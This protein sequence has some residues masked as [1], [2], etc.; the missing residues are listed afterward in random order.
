MRQKLLLER[1]VLVHNLKSNGLPFPV[2]RSI[3]HGW[4]KDIPR[5]GDRV[6]FTGCTYQ[7]AHLG[8]RYDKLLEKVPKSRFVSKFSSLGGLLVRPDQGE[9]ERAYNVLRRMARLL[10]ES[11]VE[12]G[13]LYEKEPYSGTILWEMGMMGEFWDYMETIR[14]LLRSEGVKEVITVDPHTHYTL[15]LGLRK[16]GIK[17]TNWLELVRPKRVV[18]NTPLTIHDSCLYTRYLGMREKVR[19]LLSGS[20]LREDPLITGRETSSCCGGPVAPVDSTVS[21]KIAQRRSKDLMKL[22]DTVVVSC[23]FCYVN[24]SPH[25]RVVDMAEVLE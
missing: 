14:E 15:L 10:T 17:V 1:D 9:V 12:F 6:I 5:G 25:V 19:G 8:A 2:D 23:P 22:A 24:L 16:D 13:Y 7:L 20:D 18:R 3:C 11:G 21:E 4:A